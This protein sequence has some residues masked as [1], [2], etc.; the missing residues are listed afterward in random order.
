MV[1]GCYVTSWF[2]NHIISTINEI[3]I[4]YHYK[5]EQILY[6]RHR[7]YPLYAVEGLQA[8]QAQA[9][10]Q[11]AL[12]GPEQCA[13]RCGLGW[14]C[15]LDG[16][17]TQGGRHGPGDAKHLVDH[18]RGLELRQT[19]CQTVVKRNDG[20]CDAHS[21][22]LARQQLRHVL[23]IA[24]CARAVPRHAHQAAEPRMRVLQKRPRVA[25]EEEEEEEGE[26]EEEVEEE[27]EEEEER[28]KGI[29]K[30]S[31]WADLVA[32]DALPLKRVIFDAAR[33]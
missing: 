28:A 29:D 31:T 30:R 19:G 20:A 16:Q 13:A 1:L 14:W 10:R 24:G 15:V 5:Y 18:Q 12:G 4:H 23:H 3:I 9:E 17:R 8:Q 27:E 7:R 6:T 21:V 32:E 26:E 2:W 22:G 11:G 33:L 25:L